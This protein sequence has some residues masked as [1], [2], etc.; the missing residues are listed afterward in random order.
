M[1]V[2]LASIDIT[3]ALIKPHVLK[4]PFAIQ[5]IQE[6]ITKNG[7]KILASKTVQFDAN[8]AEQFYGEHKERF[9]FNR[10]VTYMTR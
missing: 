7:L 10:L 9:F 6:K 3:L 5:N 2:K 1:G 4:H 8:L